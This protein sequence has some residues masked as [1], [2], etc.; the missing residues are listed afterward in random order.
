MNMEEDAENVLKYMA[1]NGLV[2]NAAKNSFLVLNYK[3][4]SEIMKIR[5]GEDWVERETSAKLLGLTFEDNQQ[6]K[7]QIF[8]KGGLLSSLSSRLFIIRRLKNLLSKKSILKMVDGLFTSKIRYGLQLLGKVR[9]CSEDPECADLKAI[10]LMQNKL[11]WT[12]NGT[13]VSDEVSTESLSKKFNIMSVNQLNAQAKLLEVWKALNVPKYPLKIRKQSQQHKRVSTRADIKERPCDVERS[14]N[15]KKTCI[16]DAIRLW[17][18]AP[19]KIALSKT[20]YQAKL[21][22]KIFTKSLPI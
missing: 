20:S 10:Q 4:T 7:A 14:A 22:I 13:M 2:A 11:L 3:Q 18:L 21:E 15:T 19:E 5:I 8:G 16:S 17:N 12:L 9:T 6:W 1:S